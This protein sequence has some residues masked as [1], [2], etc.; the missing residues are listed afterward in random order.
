MCFQE[1][2]YFLKVA[3]FCTSVLYQNLAVALKVPVS[4][5]YSAFRR[6]S[7]SLR[8][9]FKAFVNQALTEVWN[10]RFVPK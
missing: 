10:K 9:T 5:G 6:V 2:A 7:L 3:L 1:G 8:H 4:R